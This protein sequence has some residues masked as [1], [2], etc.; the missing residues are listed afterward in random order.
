[1]A[2]KA[3]PLDNLGEIASRLK[4]ARE[5]IGI[6]QVDAAERLGLK[7]PYLNRYEAGVV[8]P[9]LGA[10]IRLAK[11]YSVSI[12][13]LLTGKKPAP[14]DYTPPELV[15]QSVPRFR[16]FA[17]EFAFDQYIPVRLLRDAVAAGAPAEVNEEDVD[18]WALIYASRDWMPN[19]PENYTCV[20]VRGLS[21]SPILKNGDI[22]AI[23]HSQKSP[24]LLDGKIVAFRV[25]EGVTI[26]W[27]KYKPE[28]EMVLGLPEN[29]AEV[30]HLVLLKG[31]EIDTGIVG[32][33]V[34]WWSK[35]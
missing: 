16:R 13:W 4:A 3:L 18:G 1:M 26:K 32:R 33:V 17:D 14:R 9:P 21:M 28:K 34:W 11:I 31:E 24:D 7:Q 22:V 20:R 15:I 29:H 23:D 30:D 10:V 5:T 2:K 25:D 35:G 27:L 12:D 19:D 8:E 6:T